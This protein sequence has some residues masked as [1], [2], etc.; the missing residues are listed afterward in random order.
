ML[1]VRSVELVGPTRGSCI[2]IEKYI[3]AT[4]ALPTTICSY[5]IWSHNFNIDILIFRNL[6]LDLCAHTAQN[7]TV[8]PAL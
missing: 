5:W 4:R 6:T 3:C 7:S 1:A 2:H 8:I